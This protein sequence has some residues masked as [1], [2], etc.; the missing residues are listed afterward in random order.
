MSGVLSVTQ[1]SPTTLLIFTPGKRKR[2]SST[3]LETCRGSGPALG[4]WE[5]SGRVKSG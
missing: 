3:S 5:I 2:A 4:W 1:L